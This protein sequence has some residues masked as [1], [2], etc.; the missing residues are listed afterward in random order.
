MINYI[1]SGW[2]RLYYL[3]LLA[4]RERALITPFKTLSRSSCN[5]SKQYFRSAQK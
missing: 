4:P 2:S 1:L 3:A 5:Q